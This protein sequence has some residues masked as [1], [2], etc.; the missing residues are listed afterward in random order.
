M[1]IHPIA[2]IHTD[3]PEKFG[4]PRQSNVVEA[5]EGQI[6]FTEKYRNPD[7]LRGIEDYTHLWLIWGFSANKQGD[8]SPTVRPPRL[9]GN[10]RKGLFATRSPF[11]PNPLGLSCVRLKK[12]DLTGPEGPVLHV[13]GADMMS[14]TPIYD[15]K[16]YM[17]ASDSYPDAGEGFA[18]KIPWRSVEVRDDEGILSSLP[19]QVR[20]TLIQILEQDPRPSYHDD[21]ERVYGMK[22][23]G[24]EVRFRVKDRILTILDVGIGQD[25]SL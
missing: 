4:I 12:V 7:F 5:L 1:D 17:P 16:P 10:I 3:F 24:Y 6:T 14:G 22:Y 25:C 8:Y 9:G 19:D 20:K 18:G 23:A 15:I 2:H 13:L 11:R 21:P